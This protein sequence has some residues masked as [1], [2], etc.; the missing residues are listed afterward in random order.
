MLLGNAPQRHQCLQLE[1][2]VLARGIVK[3]QR[4][5]CLLLLLLL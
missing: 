2:R 4:Q 1:R 5:Q 3:Q